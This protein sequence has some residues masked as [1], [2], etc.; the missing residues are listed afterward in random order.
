MKHVSKGILFFDRKCLVTHDNSL[1]DIKAL[2]LPS[3]KT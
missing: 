2:Y 3:H 1:L